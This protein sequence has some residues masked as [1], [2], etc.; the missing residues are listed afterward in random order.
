[1]TRAPSAFGHALGA[2]DLD[3]STVKEVAVVGD[4]SAP[5]TIALVHEVWSRY[6]PN[7]VL[8]VGVPD[9]DSGTVPLLAGRTLVDG[10]P[11]AYVC[12]RFTC[13]R[14]V[15]APGELALELSTG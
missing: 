1:M 12:E 15:T 14:P 11:A 4:P 8:A 13:R 2:L 10:A 7:A 5:A 6:L 3:R 9:G